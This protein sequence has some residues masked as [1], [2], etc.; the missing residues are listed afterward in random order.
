MEPTSRGFAEVRDVFFK[1]LVEISKNSL[2]GGSKEKL[3][4]VSRVLLAANPSFCTWIHARSFFDSDISSKR[5]MRCL[6]V[7][8]VYMTNRKGDCVH[9]ILATRGQKNSTINLQIK[10]DHLKK[11][12][13]NVFLL[14]GYGFI[15]TIQNNNYFFRVTSIPQAHFSTS[16]L[17]HPVLLLM[18]Q[19]QYNHPSST[20]F[21][22]DSELW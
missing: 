14:H 19:R 7:K 8:A 5:H 4:D 15:A 2:N 3:G 18:T 20:T 10:R 12:C 6:K 13:Q 16:A 17:H 22:Q 11:H 1:E 9:L 21:I